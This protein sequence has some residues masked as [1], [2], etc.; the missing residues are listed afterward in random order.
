[1][2]GKTALAA[3]TATCSWLLIIFM[4]P[5]G[6]GSATSAA[7][8][9]AIGGGQSASARSSLKAG[10]ALI[11]GSCS[12]LG[13]L[14]FLGRG[15]AARLFSSDEEVLAT[16][17]VLIIILVV[18]QLFDGIQTVLEGGLIGLGLQRGASQVKLISM[19][20]V[21][22]G[23]AYVLAIALRVGV[24]G[25]WVAGVLG[26]LV[27]VCLYIR[28]LRRCDFELLASSAQQQLVQRV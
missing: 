16:M 10:A 9:H 14:L 12:A 26:M 27:T 13:L 25:I 6:L 7:V 2:C 20:V 21:R 3:H 5:S 24:S 28:L 4:V 19:V 18:F 17:N 8:G 22:L 1:L 23:G 15:L 11:L